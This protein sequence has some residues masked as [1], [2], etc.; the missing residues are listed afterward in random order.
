MV[1]TKDDG[2]RDAVDLLVNVIPTKEE[3][4]NPRTSVAAAVEAAA[5]ATAT[6]VAPQQQQQQQRQKNK[7]HVVVVVLGDLGRSPRMQYH[8][9]SLLQEGH[10]VSLVGYH[11]E[12]LITDLRM[13]YD[14]NDN[15]ANEQTTTEGGGGG[16]TSTTTTPQPH[17]SHQLQQQQDSEQERERLLT[18]HDRNRSS[19]HRKG[20]TLRVIRFTVPTPP[21]CCGKIVYFVWRI[22]TLALWTSW[23]LVGRIPSSVPVDAVLVQNPPALPLL[24]VA[25]LYCRYR[26]WFCR[27]TR[28]TMTMTSSSSTDETSLGTEREHDNV[29][30]HRHHRR[31]QRPALILD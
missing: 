11:G 23:A 18:G 12:D 6:T 9:L 26:Q 30:H 10:D 25:W 29:R 24:L 19:V 20:P 7:L 4:G 22:V 13:Y 21:S 17:Q 3:D 14:D 31:R 1:T 27:Q 15:D 2:D 5:T 16:G 8:A 28:T